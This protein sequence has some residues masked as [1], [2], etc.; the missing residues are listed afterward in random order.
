MGTILQSRFE[1]VGR[2]M[3]SVGRMK[4][5]MLTKISSVQAVQLED[6]PGN[7]KLIEDAIRQLRKEH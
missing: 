1:E 5:A 6:S 3:G 2:E 7:L 4:L